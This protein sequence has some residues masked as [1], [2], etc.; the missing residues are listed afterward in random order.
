MTIIF[1]NAS[2]LISSLETFKRT[3]RKVDKN[4]LPC[5]NSSHVTET[6]HR[7]LLGETLSVVNI[8]KIKP[9]LF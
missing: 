5:G 1:L 7:I 8:A 3:I 6:I 4:I 2:S 9:K